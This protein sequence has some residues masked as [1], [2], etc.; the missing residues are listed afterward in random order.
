VDLF[1]NYGINS[2]QADFSVNGPPG[3]FVPLSFEKKFIASHDDEINTTLSSWVRRKW[4]F[5]LQSDFLLQMDIEG[6]EFH[7]LLAT[8]DELLKRFRIVVLELHWTEQ[9]TSLFAFPIIEALI[10]KMLQHYVVVHFHPNNYAGKV[11][12]SNYEMP[13]VIELT[14]LRKDRCGIIEARDEIRHPLD[15]PCNP[16]LP[17]IIMDSGFLS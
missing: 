11:N 16:D 6:A 1:N 14:L 10:K 3:G 9:W 2:H 15:N 8:P 4:E 5:G 12:V 13:R 7:C 17:D